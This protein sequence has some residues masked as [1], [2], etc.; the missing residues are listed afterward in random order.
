M[1]FVLCCDHAKPPPV[2]RLQGRVK[3]SIFLTAAASFWKEHRT[4]HVAMEILEAFNQGQQVFHADCSVSE[5]M[6]PLA[7]WQPV[8]S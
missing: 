2:C 5:A 4:I 3:E 7:V 1:L 6:C 8:F